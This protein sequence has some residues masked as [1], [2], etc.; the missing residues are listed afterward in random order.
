MFLDWLSKFNNGNV[1]FLCLEELF[2][3]F[4]NRIEK[5]SIFLK[6]IIF[7][8]KTV[9]N[10]I[11]PILSLSHFMHFKEKIDLLIICNLIFK[12]SNLLYW[13]DFNTTFA[14]SLLKWNLKLTPGFS[15]AWVQNSNLTSIGGIKKLVI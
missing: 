6:L 1:C 3:K 12:V 9:L 4:Y 10:Y 13:T 5:H 8:Y 2:L 15:V 11:L 7:A 14:R